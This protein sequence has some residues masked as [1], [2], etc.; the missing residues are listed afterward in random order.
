MP[1]DETVVRCG[2]CGTRLDESSGLAFEEREPCPQCGSTRRAFE[3][4][5]SSTIHL[6]GSVS[7][8]VTRVRESI[9]HHPGWWLLSLALVVVGAFAGVFISGP[10]GVLLGLSLG[11]LGV[12][13]G[14]RTT[15]HHRREVEERY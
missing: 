1:H 6:S 14:T 5:I 12:L 8:V 11:L 9:E 4:K 3:A 2:E 13:V 10:A 15:I 7:A